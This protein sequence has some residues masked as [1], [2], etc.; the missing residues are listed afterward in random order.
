MDYFSLIGVVSMSDCCKIIPKTPDN[1]N[2][3]VLS[4]T[5][6]PHSDVIPKQAEDDDQ[7]ICLWLNGLS[8]GA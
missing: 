3:Q 1:N 7:L 6:N 2:Y 5:D 8:R 4:G